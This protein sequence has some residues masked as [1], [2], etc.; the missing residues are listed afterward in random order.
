MPVEL[1]D[2]AKEPPVQKLKLAI[3]GREKHGK[4]WLAATA[5]KPILVHDFDGRSESLN[6]K[7]GVYVISYV[8]PVWPKM[9]DAAQKFLDIVGKLE[10]S[11]DLAELGFAVPKGTIVRTNVIDSIQTFG[12]AFSAYALYGQKDIRREIVFGNYKVFLGA[13]WDAWNAEMKPVEDSFLRLAGLPPDIIITLHE[14]LE[15][16][17]DSTSDKPKYTGKVG[18]YPVRYQRLLKYVNELWRVKNTQIVSNGRSVFLP[19]VYTKPTFDFDASTAMEL[20]AVEEPDIAKLI[21]KHEAALR[22]KGLLGASPKAL[23][24]GVKA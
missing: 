8:D 11:L 9:P 15:E 1:H 21:T 10:T 3:V 20:D 4:S 13:G 7:D 14:T 22:S 18:V 2:S 16:S 12:K 6:G 24:P 23:P 17:E 5:R 19:R